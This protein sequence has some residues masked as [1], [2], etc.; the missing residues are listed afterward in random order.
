[1]FDI[2]SLAAWKGKEAIKQDILTGMQIETCGI[3]VNSSKDMG[4]IHI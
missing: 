1:M 4:S 2:Q 3:A